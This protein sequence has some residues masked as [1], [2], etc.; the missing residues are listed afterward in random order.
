MKLTVI[1]SGSA[2]N[3]YVLE[4]KTSALIIECGVRPEAVFRETSVIPSRVAGVLV[5]HEHHDHAGYAARFAQRGMTIYASGGTLRNT[6]LPVSSRPVRLTPMISAWAGHFLI[7]PF[8]V[9]HDAAEPLGFLIE[10]PESGRILF[11]TDT[12]GAEFNFR[13]FAVDHILVE[14]NYADDILTRRILDGEV[15]PDRATRV[16]RTHLSLRGA[17]DFIQAN[18]TPSLKTVT[19]IHLSDENSDAERFARAAAETAPFATIRIATPGL[20]FDMSKSEI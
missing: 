2:G 16:R 1:S 14:A 9:E 17:L 15:A 6:T 13:G 12:A 4:G 18:E 11:V 10:H 5:S 8:R 7:R 19:L 3:C 20:S